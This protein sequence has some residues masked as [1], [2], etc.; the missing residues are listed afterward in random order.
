MVH[1]LSE[2]NSFIACDNNK[3][4]NT[5]N[6]MKGG[7]KQPTI[8]NQ[9]QRFQLNKMIWTASCLLILTN[10]EHTLYY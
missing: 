9:Q 3:D 5:W 6:E 2:L 4:K 1:F 7:K 8:Q 10:A